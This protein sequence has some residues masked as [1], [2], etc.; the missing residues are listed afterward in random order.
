MS[1]LNPI[2]PARKGSM[3]MKY[4]RQEKLKAELV[5]AGFW[6]ANAPSDPTKHWAALEELCERVQKRLAE[7][8]CL[9]VYPLDGAKQSYQVLLSYKNE[10]QVIG[11]GEDI[12]EA[13]CTAAVTL[14]VLLAQHPEYAAANSSKSRGNCDLPISQ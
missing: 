13:M 12:Y 1:D 7:A 4:S 6:E 9:F 14:P 5:K 8:A 10:D 3:P 11:T 2:Q